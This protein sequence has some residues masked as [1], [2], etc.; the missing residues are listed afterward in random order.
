MIKCRLLF[1]LVS[2]WQL[3]SYPK[4]NNITQPNHTDPT[5]ETEK[6]STVLNNERGYQLPPDDEQ[7]AGQG[8]HLLGEELQPEVRPA[9]GEPDQ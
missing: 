4:H 2:V 3:G 9:G 7:L 1:S 5:K 8:D 6:S